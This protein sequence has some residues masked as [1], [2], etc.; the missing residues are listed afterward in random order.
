[1]NCEHS[2]ELL[3]DALEGL[4]DPS[5][6]AAVNDHLEG[7]EACQREAEKVKEIWE[8]LGGLERVRT[9]DAVRSR[10]YAMLASETS[11]PA[12]EP[13]RRSDRIVFRPAGRWLRRLA[14]PVAIAMA[15]LAIGVTLGVRLG[16]GGQE[17][18]RELRTEMR[19]F[20]RAVS[21]SLLEH[22]SASERLRAVSLIQASTPDDRVI[23]SLLRAINDDPSVNVRLAALDV[24]AGLAHRPDVKTGLLE[25]FPMQR[26]PGMQV[27]MAKI[28][29]ALDEERSREE[30]RRLLWQ[31]PRRRRLRLSHRKEGRGRRIEFRCP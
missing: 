16:D 7:C 21:L 29:L 5:L 13:P 22:Q 23:A 20:T 24:L 6:S 19:L 17:E 12:G 9:S 31:R 27:G 14:F 1:M 30:I 8:M 28:L 4:L 3:L 15:A 10:F 26:S 25:A 11:S 18:I 2:R